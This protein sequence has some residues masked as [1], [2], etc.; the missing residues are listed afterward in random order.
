MDLLLTEEQSMLRQSVGAFARRLGGGAQLRALHKLPGRF[1]AREFEEAAAAGWLALLLPPDQGGSGLGLTEL[2]LVAEDLGGVLS[3]LPLTPAIGGIVALAGSEVPLPPGMLDNALAGKT[4]IVPAFANSAGG[5]DRP[6]VSTGGELQ[7]VRF[8][9]VK[10]AVPSAS[11]ATGFVINALIANE[12]AL[13]YVRRDCEGVGVTEKIAIDGTVLGDVTLK[14]VRGADTVLLARGAAANAL[15]RKI[16]II[17]N[18]GLAAELLGIMHAAAIRTLDYLR[19]RVQFG[20]PIGSFQALQHRAVNDHVQVEATRS[21]LYEA[22]KLTQFDDNLEALACAAKIKAAEA[23]PALIASC[24]QMHGAIGFTDEHDIG[25]MLKRAMTLAV[26]YGPP[27]AQRQRY[28]SLLGGRGGIA[29]PDIRSPD[30][31]GEAFRRE[32]REWIEATLPGDLRDLPTRPPVDRATWWHRQLFKR[33]W[34][35]PRWPKA[36]GGMEAPLQQ[37]IIL[38]EELGRAG[39]PEL[40]AQGISHIGPIL[41]AF[42][43]E[44]QKARHLP[45]ILSGDAIW[46]QGYSEPGAGSDLAGLRTAAVLDGDQFRHQRP[47]NLDHLGAP[48]RLDVCPGTHRPGGREAGRHLIHPDRHE[49]ARHHG[50]PDPHHRKRRGTC[51]SVLRQCARAAREP[52][53]RTQRRLADRQCAPGARTSAKLE[54]AEMRRRVGAPEEGRRRFGRPRSCFPRQ[55]GDR[56][57]RSAG[58]VGGL[59]ARGGADPFRPSAGAGVVVPQACRQ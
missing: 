28:A 54:P 1:A 23:A 20:R 47:E 57:D 36:Y 40:S 53:R 38:M 2:C 39:A 19:I 33:G 43:S 18:F 10:V 11:A 44:Q 50:A 4:L 29:L 59:R 49:I 48:R 16:G 51:R 46:C 3:A 45:R 42:A 30:D 25:L 9:G 6:I 37:Q 52:D 7:D 32:V 13:I 17:L 27:G 35:A 24:I 21:L 56:R 41:L 15:T 34:I 8:S 5:D 31:S 26:T 14:D 22:A 55:A 58:T 12:A